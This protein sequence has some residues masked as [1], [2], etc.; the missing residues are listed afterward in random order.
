MLAILVRA[1]TAFA[2]D[3]YPPT[4][5][6]SVIEAVDER[7][8][9]S[10]GEVGQWLRDNLVVSNRRDHLLA[11]DDLIAALAVDHPPDDK[12]RYAGQTRKNVLAMAR[13]VVQ[14]LPAAK[15]NRVDGKQRRC[16]RGVRLATQAE[17]QAAWDA[18]LTD[19]G[20]PPNPGLRDARL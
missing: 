2:G 15:L 9:A 16:Y 5:I 14:G 13:E 1:A 12:G 19:A 7:R 11:T 10:I 4:D 8:Q 6:P 18:M 17:L 3:P 20:E